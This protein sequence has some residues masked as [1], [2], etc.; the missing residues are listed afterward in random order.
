M[1]V[2]GVSQ[3]NLNHAFYA[4]LVITAQ[5]NFVWIFVYC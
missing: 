1:Y 4:L 3:N 2:P 5:E